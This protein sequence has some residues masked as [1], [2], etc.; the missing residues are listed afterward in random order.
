M[1]SVTH[2]ACMGEMMH[3]TKFFAR[4]CKRKDLAVGMR[5]I[6]VFRKYS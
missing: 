2:I 1:R 5:K 4:K 3:I 6:L